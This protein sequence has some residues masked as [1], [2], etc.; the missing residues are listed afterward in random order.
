MQPF[1]LRMIPIVYIWSIALLLL[2]RILFIRIYVYTRW[3]E[4]IGT[5]QHVF[6]HVTNKTWHSYFKSFYFE[7]IYFSL[8]MSAGTRE[9][10]LGHWTL[11]LQSR[12]SIYSL[13]FLKYLKF[14]SCKSII[15]SNISVNTSS[16]TNQV[17]YRM[18]KVH[19]LFSVVFFFI[20]IG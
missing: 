13:S 7:Q 2:Y 19:I 9:R 14:W 17:F 16:I 3:H 18:L 5:F 4:N 10:I 12:K 1:P 20:V 8:H 11:W 6:T 15:F